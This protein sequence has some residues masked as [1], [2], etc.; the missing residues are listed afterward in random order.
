MLKKLKRKYNIK[1][2]FQW[3]TT[4]QDWSLIYGKAVRVCGDI[5]NSNRLSDNKVNNICPNCG[6]EKVVEK[7]IG[8]RYDGWAMGSSL[9]KC[10]HCSECQMDWNPHESKHVYPWEIINGWYKELVDCID[11][12]MTKEEILTKCD[13]FKDIHAESF[14]KI[15]EDACAFQKEDPKKIPLK[16]LR[17]IFK[18]V[19]DEKNTT[20]PADQVTS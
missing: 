1:N 7:M 11:K 5:N 3:F 10:R 12:K 16:T 15:Y 17:T 20:I 4:Q 19:F 13:K 6:S 2:V 14:K 9:Q 18:S 8:Y